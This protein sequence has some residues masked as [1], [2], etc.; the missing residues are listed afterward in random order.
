MNRLFSAHDHP[1]LSNAVDD[2]HAILNEDDAQY[3]NE[4]EVILIATLDD[5]RRFVEPLDDY[6]FGYAFNISRHNCN[7]MGILFRLIFLNM[8]VCNIADLNID[9]IK[10]VILHE[11]GHQLNYPELV[12]FIDLQR[13]GLRPNFAEVGRI[14]QIRKETYAD[15]YA[16]RHGY[17]EPLQSSMIIY[18]EQFGV[19][20]G[21][22][23]ERND[24]L[25]NDDELN[26][27]TL[28]QHL[29]G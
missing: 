4:K 12:R 9:E 21:F 15:E 16:K 10:A 13:Q 20:V 24:S 14:N 8:V 1:V 27:V 28:P 7:N 25:A 18:H 29:F 19:P 17:L 2:L 22:E 26:G 5:V 3:R 11:L 23:N 6:D